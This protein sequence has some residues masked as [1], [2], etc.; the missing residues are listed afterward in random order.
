[1]L[2]QRLGLGR[3]PLGF[4]RF[5]GGVERARQFLVDVC[6]PQPQRECPFERPPCRL[7][8]R[9][10]VVVAPEVEPRLRESRIEFGGSLGVFERVR[11]VAGLPERVC[12][13]AFGH[14]RE[15]REPALALLPALAVYAEGFKRRSDG[16]VVLLDLGVGDPTAGPRFHRLPGVLGREPRDAGDHVAGLRVLLD[17]EIGEPH[18]EQRVEVHVFGSVVLRVQQARHR[19]RVRRVDAERVG[20]SPPHSSENPR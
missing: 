12:E 20:L 1:M 13:V 17:G 2:A 9:P 6:L 11:G 16:L 7:P 15:V 4:D 8:Q 5:V 10:L 14:R 18:F 3:H 19:V